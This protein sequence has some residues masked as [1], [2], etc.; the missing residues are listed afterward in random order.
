[1]PK[2]IRVRAPAKINL[3]LSVGPLRPDGYHDLATVF[4][5]VTLFDDLTVRTGAPGSGI[6]LTMI[7]ADDVSTGPDNLACRA[8]TLLA[9]HV[10]RA[11]DVEIAITKAI[12]VA[13]GMAGGSADAA[14]VLVALDALWH[15]G[16]GRAELA[17]LGA[18]LGSDVP[19]AVH[20]GTVVGTGRGERLTPVLARGEFHWVVALSDDGLSTPGVYR[21]IDR[22][23]AQQSVPEPVVSDDLMQALR[24]GDPEALGRSLSNDLQEAALS[25]RP[26]L[27]MLLEAGLDN[28]ALGGIVS[29]SGPTCVFL[30]RDREAALTCA[31]GLTMSGLIA[32]VRTVT[33]PAPGA[34]VVPG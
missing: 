31:I 17:S 14:G 23:R 21:E 22:L 30:A 13:G 9:D 10:G 26:R 7:G 27:G 19:F 2:E 3:G 8:A 5:A 20:G 24:S 25:L 15:L 12:P 11:P 4:H 29:G 18:A 34:R 1:M 16:L 6:A 28:G 32:G 33:G